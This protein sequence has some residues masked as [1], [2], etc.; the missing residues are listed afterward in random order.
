[1]DSRF[2]GNDIIGVQFLFPVSCVLFPL[3][4]FLLSAFCRLPF[5]GASTTTSSATDSTRGRV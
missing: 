1:M 2:R 5:H 4:P 3:Q